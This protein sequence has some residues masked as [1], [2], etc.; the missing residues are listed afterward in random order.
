VQIP[1]SVPGQTLE[2]SGATTITTGKFVTI[3]STATLDTNG[4][5]NSGT[6][7]VTGGTLKSTRDTFTNNSGATLY[8][9]A[10]T[11]TFGG[12][13]VQ[14]NDGLQ[15]HGTLTLVDTTVN[16]DV[17]S[18]A[19]SSVAIAGA[20]TFNGLV[21]GAGNFTG[22]GSAIFAG[23]Y[24]P[25][26]SPALVTHAGN[27]TFDSTNRLIMEIGGLARGTGYDALDVEGLLTFGGELDLDFINGFTAS[28]GDSFDLFDWGNATGSFSLLNL[29]DLS[30][31]LAWDFSQLYST[32]TLSVTA[33]PEPSTYAALTG[34]AALGCVLL[35]RR[36]SSRSPQ[37]SARRRS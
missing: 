18:A 33:I 26:D 11:L 30:D 27:L 36:K 9:T 4:G 29:P 28:L 23:G 1:R 17:H 10:A 32:G 37:E 7:F 2:L 12:D 5:S 14:N 24:S 19:G 22:S 35:R 6:F 20:V 3:T 8:A 25:G 13:G 21:S 16:G 31:G 15:N 34:V